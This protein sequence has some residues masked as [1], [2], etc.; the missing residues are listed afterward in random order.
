MAE[1]HDAI[2]G[3]SVVECG[4][5]RVCWSVLAAG[6][7]W[8]SV[9]AVSAEPPGPAKPAPTFTKD[10]API[11][12]RKC[13]PCHRRHHVGPFA[14]ETYEQARKRASD[15][16]AVVEE[17][18][19][20]PWKPAPGVGPKLKHD[21]S[22]TSEE[23]TVLTAWSEG[24][25]PQGDPKDMPPPA[26]FAAGW[27]LGP[28]DLV[29]EAKEDFALWA[30][31]PD[32]YRCF[33]L[34]TNL[35]QDTYVSAI[36]FQP[37]N[38]RIVHHINAFID[39]TGDARKR[40]EAEPGP[41]YTSFGGPGIEYFEEVSFWAAGHEASHLPAG[42]GQRFPRQ[43]DIVLQVH[44]HPTG[45]PERDRTRIG[46]Y[47][48]RGRVKQALH[49]SNV[50]NQKFQIPA[51]QPSTEIKASWFIPTDLEA[52]AVSP[53]MHQLGRDMRITLTLPSGR[54][55]DLIHIPAW[56]PTWQSAYYFQKPISLPQGSVVKVVAHFDNSAHP[57]NPNTPPQ[58]VKRGFGADD[59]MCEGFIAVVKKGQDLTLPRATDDLG[60]IFARQRIRKMIKEINKQS[61]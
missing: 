38:R 22:L 13:Q 26:Q 1:V 59:E 44:Y 32:T 55:Q 23:I 11:L 54:T 28:P 19:M 9:S 47:F 14:L 58:C 17:R 30:S 34:P 25:A 61:R 16:A 4:R 60:D 53:H 43:S 27:K 41:G 12:Q 36:D 8:L 42:I 15:I 40:D 48:S 7:L 57:R 50:S 33:V 56:D 49:W 35:A 31:G 6:V 46:V 10:V 3:G 2:A 52:L 37:G 18:R 5:A 51:G 45:K 39:T 21:Q 24:G 29:L 20:P